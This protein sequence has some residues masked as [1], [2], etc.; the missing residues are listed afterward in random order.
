MAVLAFSAR[1]WSATYGLT[2]AR[3]VPID[4][5]E[6]GIAA[7][8]LLFPEYCARTV[9]S[10]TELA[11]RFSSTLRRRRRTSA[12]RGYIPRFPSVSCTAGHSEF[13]FRASP[14]IHCFEGSLRNGRRVRLSPG[15]LAG[16]AAAP[17][18][19]VKACYLAASKRSVCASK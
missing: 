3:S 16:W 11:Y 12:Y 14:Y 9:F 19:C 10:E 8:S 1:P 7:G 15:V 17:A 6:R 5:S 4:I 2:T 18:L 13:R